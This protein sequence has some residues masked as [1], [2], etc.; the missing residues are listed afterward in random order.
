MVPYLGLGCNKQM[1]EFKKI[2]S[3]LDHL[4]HCSHNDRQE[5]YCL[6]TQ[7]LESCLLHM[8]SDLEG[9]SFDLGLV[10]SFQ[11]M[12]TAEHLMAPGGFPREEALQPQ[13]R[14]ALWACNPMGPKSCFLP[15]AFCILSQRVVLY[16]VLAA[17]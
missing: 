2:T 15:R 8:S 3:D 4:P 14:F 7:G 9:W 16:S 11:T 1:Y 12:T 10:I 6:L 13:L 5:L 17:L